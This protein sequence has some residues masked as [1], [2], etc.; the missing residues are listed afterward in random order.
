MLTAEWGIT[1]KVQCMV[2]D[3]ASNMILSAQLLHLRHVPC[4]AHNLNLIVKKALDQTPVINEIC[5]KARKIVGLFRSSCKAK[6]KLVEM[7]GLMGRPAL[8]LIQEVETRWNSTF[9]I[10]QREPVGAALS[11]LNN[12]TSHLTSL[13][14]DIIQQSLSL[15]QPFKLATTEM[16]EEQSVCFKAYTTVEDVAAQACTEKRKCNTGINCTIR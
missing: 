3:N 2:T 7:Q 5:Q 1:S 10:L 13:E 12:D 9:D 15:Q 11:N 8:K 4:F 6:D 14:Y 16:T